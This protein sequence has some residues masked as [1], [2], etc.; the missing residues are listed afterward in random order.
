MT[1]RL[2]L[3]ALRADAILRLLTSPRGAGVRYV[4]DIHA[5]ADLRGWQRIVIDVAIGDLVADGKIEEDAVGVLRV[6][7]EAA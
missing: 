1:T 6:V 3:R 2:S 5:L 4:E 7:Q